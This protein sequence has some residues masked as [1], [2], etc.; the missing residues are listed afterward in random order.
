MS[1]QENTC[2]YMDCRGRETWDLYFTAHDIYDLA[3][4]PH[5]KLSFNLFHVTFYI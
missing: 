1:L 2:F 5:E 4:S 3:I